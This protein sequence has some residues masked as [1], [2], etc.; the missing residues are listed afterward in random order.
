MKFRFIAGKNCRDF[1]V[2]ESIETEKDFQM[3]AIVE[4]VLS[5]EEYKPFMKGD[6]DKHIRYSYLFNKSIFPYQFWFDVRN[7]LSQTTGYLCEEK[8]LELLDDPYKTGHYR[9]PITYEEFYDW[10]YSLKLPDD[11]SVDDEKYS[12]QP[13]S[14][15]RAINAHVARIEVATAG[16]KT[17]LTYLYCK[18]L[19]Q[20][21]GIKGK[22]LIIVPSQTLCKQ[23]KDDFYH[24]DSMNDFDQ[25]I[26]V[27]TIYANSKRLVDAEIV[28]GTY[29]SLSNYEEDYFEDFTVCICDELHRAKA[30]SIRNAIY[31]KLRNVQY[32]FGMTGTFPEYKTLDYIHIVSMFGPEVMNVSAKQL[33]DTGVANY[34]AI[35]MIQ[36]EYYNTNT[37]D[38]NDR[39]KNFSEI[40]KEFPEMHPEYFETHPDLVI[41]NE[42]EGG[43]WDNPSQRYYL[44]KYYYQHNTARLKVLSNLINK[45]EE[46]SI[47]FVDTVQ[48]CEEIYDFLT[49][50]CP[51][52]ERKFFIIHGSVKHRDDILDEVK[53]TNGK[54]VIIATYGTMS[55]GVSIKNLT[56]AYIVD[57]GK[58][59]NR[60]RQSIGRL[61]RIIENKKT[62]KVFDFCDDMNGS[63][64]KKQAK[65]RKSTYEFNNF[66]VSSFRIKILK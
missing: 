22:I 12:Y 16:G 9:S 39:I 64:F 3:Y 42:D 51:D 18:C 6:F 41:P 61:M 40:V 52:P 37:N 30:Y 57:G 48:Y 24:Y 50:N 56:N 13:E 31:A 21:I 19:M 23:L 63:S 32:F 44:E 20:V 4:K 65:I 2:M 36:L 46:N 1:V 60:I 7:A 35:K 27:E 25:Q 15:I 54:C 17:F 47:V 28:C 59:S 33:M 58:S 11:I 43:K 53:S 45:F 14:A 34:T 62:S 38:P 10:V 29:Q 5:R 66:D 26:V 55:T 8:D 49:A